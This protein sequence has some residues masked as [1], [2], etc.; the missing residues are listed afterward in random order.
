MR[1]CGFFLGFMLFSFCAGSI[2]AQSGVPQAS[3]VA[4]VQPVRLDSELNSI[5]AV[6]AKEKIT[7][8][9]RH[10][11]LV[12]LARVQML[13]GDIEGAAATW[14]QAAY[15]ENGKR[16]DSA[17]LENTACLMAMG[18]W[19]KADANIKL[20]LLTGRDDRKSYIK[21]KFLG[22][23][24]EAFRGS[25]PV[26]IG[27]YLDDSDFAQERAMIFYTLWKITGAE[28]YK[29]RLVIEYP[30]SPETKALLVDA[31]LITGVS[32][33]PGAMWLL[34]ASPHPLTVSNVIQ[35]PQFTLETAMPPAIQT[36][37]FTARDNALA[38]QSA[39]SEKGFSAAVSVRQANGYD[40]WAV[41]VPAGS[42]LNQ[43]I[44]KL[45]TAGYETLPV[46]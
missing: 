8:K 36:G 46:Y 41:T 9:E 21:A 16:D 33:F 18:E 29:N 20:V 24:I 26:I 39:L 15:A 5:R 42:D 14:E 19:D 11:A 17:L 1:K 27:S 35:S 10:D 31:G 32:I 22:A 37:L 3:A 25:N 34:P 7:G 43:T 38:Q 40:Y 12:R 30:E 45:K 6:L 4:A 28:E 44:I 23:Q 13:T 2:F